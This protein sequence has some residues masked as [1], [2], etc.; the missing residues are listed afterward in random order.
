M[1]ERGIDFKV[2]F[3]EKSNQRLERESPRLH[4]SVT[5]FKRLKRRVEPN[6]LR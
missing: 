1:I 5:N 4:F 2:N 6:S 3:D